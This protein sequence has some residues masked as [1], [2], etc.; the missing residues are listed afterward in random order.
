MNPIR[1]RDA[2]L[3]NLQSLSLDIPKG[4]LVVITG[5]SGSGK[6]TLAF[7]LLYR[8]GRRSYERAIGSSP[9]MEEEIYD[10]ITGIVPTVAVEQ[11]IIRQSNPRSLVGTRTRLL[12]LMAA[13]L[14]AWW[15]IS[16]YMWRTNGPFPNLPRL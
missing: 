16:V 8:E 11:R 10:E 12:G 3:H 9:M 15:A 6:S 2:R 5:V 7:D 1:I 13:C 14:L 4:Q